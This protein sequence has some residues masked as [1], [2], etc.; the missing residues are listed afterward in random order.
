MNEEQVFEKI[1]SEYKWYAPFMSAQ[2]AGTYVRRF[3]AG[4]LKPST[5]KRF[6]GLFGYQPKK[7]EWIKI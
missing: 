7:V 5:L 2:T 6:F 4:T 1:T 3:K